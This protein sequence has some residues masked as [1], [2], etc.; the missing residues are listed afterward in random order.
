MF[1]VSSTKVWRQHSPDTPVLFLFFPHFL[2]HETQIGFPSSQ[3]S[4][5]H[6]QL[7][8]GTSAPHTSV[9]FCFR[10]VD[11]RHCI[12]IQVLIL[13][14]QIPKFISKHQ[15]QNLMWL[16]LV[17]PPDCAPPLH[18]IFTI[19]KS[20]KPHGKHIFF[21]YMKCFQLMQSTQKWVVS[22][23]LSLLTLPG[24]GLYVIW[25]LEK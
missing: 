6:K 3:Q 2:S 20:A 19:R 22:I 11:K 18:P 17:R 1:E 23:V 10:W 13:K 24:M 7:T 8:V 21:A 25:T 15:K 4:T 16:Q 12:K 9:T 14:S 5:A